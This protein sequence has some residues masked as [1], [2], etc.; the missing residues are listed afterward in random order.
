MLF[1]QFKKIQIENK[2]REVLN[3]DVKAL[4]IGMKLQINFS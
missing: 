3:N 1:M 4:S 2:I